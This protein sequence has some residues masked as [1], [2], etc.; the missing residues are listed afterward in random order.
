MVA[1]KFTVKLELREIQS[2]VPKLVEPDLKNIK[3]RE[4]VWA[5]LDQEYGQVTELTKDLVSELMKFMVS[6]EVRTE[7][8]LL[9]F[10]ICHLSGLC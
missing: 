1:G 9:S 5:L 10:L 7:H 2:N 6:K 4:E 3:T 8:S